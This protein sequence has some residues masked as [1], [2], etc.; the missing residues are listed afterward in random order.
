MDKI[1]AAAYLLFFSLLVSHTPLGSCASINQQGMS[2][3]HSCLH[4]ACNLQMDSCLNISIPIILFQG[5]LFSDLE[6]IIQMDL[7]QIGEWVAQ[8]KARRWPCKWCFCSIVF[9]F[10]SHN[11]SSYFLVQ[12]RQVF[13]FNLMSIHDVEQKNKEC[14]PETAPTSKGSPSCRITQV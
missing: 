4:G 2:E 10:S 3:Q 8:T 6:Q 12:R 5:K 13:F 1:R 9:S 14:H 11:P 7:P